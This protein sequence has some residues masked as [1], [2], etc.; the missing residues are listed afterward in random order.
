MITKISISNFALIEQLQL[1]LT[2]GFSIIT[3]ETGAG[4]SILLGALGLILGKRADLSSL[5]NESV[6]CVIEGHFDVSGYSLQDFFG[7]ND[8]DYDDH[9]VLRREI[10]PTGKSRAFVNDSPVNLNQLQELGQRLVDIHSQHQTLSLSEE[11]F[12]FGL[13]DAYGGHKPML[14]DFNRHL[15]NYRSL[16][17]E[18]RDLQQAKADAQKEQGYNQYLFDELFAAQLI[19]DEQ[20]RLEER[21]QEL[22]NAE[23][24]REN[25]SKASGLL[26]AEGFG[27]RNSAVEMRQALQKLSAISPQFE[28]LSQRA[29]GLAIELADMSAEIDRLSDK[30]SEDPAALEAVNE[31]LKLLQDLQAKHQV[32]DVA[33]LILVRDE[34]ENRIGSFEELDSKIT[35]AENQ[36]ASE[37]AELNRLSAL[38][39][40]SRLEKIPELISELKKI[41]AEIGMPDAGFDFIFTPTESFNEFGK[42]SLEILFSANQGVGFSALKKIAS[43]GELSRIMLAVK[44]V[45][46]RYSEL[47]T[48]IFD[49]IDT[50]VSGEIAHKMAGIMKQMSQQMQIIAITH[51]P[52]IAAKGNAHLKVFKTVESGVAKSSIRLLS[53]EERVQEIAQ[54][55][56]G[57]IVSD[58]AINHARA[59]LN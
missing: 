58:S 54:M 28:E 50:G 2:P 45:L 34:L 13:I 40:E 8:L 44:A 46:A 9:T 24:I 12:Q 33:G 19:D 31:R 39:R 30:V 52:Q 4:K 21:W 5:K 41:L 15:K 36:L 18:L 16:N 51:L 27:L 57:S 48:L 32:A 49:E 35:A 11:D 10:L 1:D 55:L 38:L 42:D 3:G 56:S 7:Q 22:N 59:L 53:E 14:Q 20:A 25:L 17:R 47:P 23:T 43:G 29:S 6:K 26:D 37:E